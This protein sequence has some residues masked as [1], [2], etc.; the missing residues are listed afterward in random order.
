MKL[1]INFMPTCLTIS[2]VGILLLLF[3][4]ITYQPT[5]IK[6]NQINSKL[7]NKQIKIRAT[8]SNVKSFEDSNF[9]II[10]VKDNSGQ[11][12]IT[13]NQILNISNNQSIIILGKVTQYKESL[14]IQSN[15][16]IASEFNDF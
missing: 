9:Q 11:I 7:L 10:S 16:I 8:V 3:I 14:Q 5:T 2:L 15:K 4:S 6:I 12:N 13:T 1:K